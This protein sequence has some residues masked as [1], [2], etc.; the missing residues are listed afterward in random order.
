MHMLLA[1]LDGQLPSAALAPSITPWLPLPIARNCIWNAIYY[2]T[3][4]KIDLELQ[5][6]HSNTANVLR[7]LGIGT[8]L[9]VAAT[10][11][12]APFDVVKSR[13]VTRWQQQQQ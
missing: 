5:P 10:C 11:F 9:G 6:F 1:E 13:W 3:M 4:Y 8:V 7:Q 12:N 2:G